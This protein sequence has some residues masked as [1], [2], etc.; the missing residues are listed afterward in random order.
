MAHAAVAQSKRKA[1]FNASCRVVGYR[2]SDP[3]AAPLH[4]L[5]HMR[6]LHRGDSPT[7]R[8]AQF[9]ADGRFRPDRRA[10]K[11]RLEDDA[12]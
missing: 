6:G 3:P 4:A 12:S 2:W 8:S 1:T 7:P 9:R 10:T 11:T 5:A